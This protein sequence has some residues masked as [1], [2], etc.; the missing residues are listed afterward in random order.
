MEFI[1]KYIPREYLAL[2]IN[3]CR[4]RLEELPKSSIQTHVKEG[5]L[6]KRIA[7]GSHRYNL[8]SPEGRKYYK[9]WLER[10][11]H[12]RH[13]KILNS[14]WNYYFKDPPSSDCRPVKAERILTVGY[15]KQVVMDKAF[16]D[17]LKNDVNT[18]H[19]KYR[20]YYFNGTYYRSA[21][22][23]DI[24]VFYT[25]MGIPFKYEPELWLAGMAQPIYPDFVIYIKELDTCIIHEHI[26]IKNSVD[27][28]RDIK[29]KYNNYVDAG[30]LSGEDFIFTYD[31]ERIHFDIR[32][33]PVELNTAVYAIT[34]SSNP[35][36]NVAS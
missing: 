28:L 26:G 30:L 24:A 11:E 36:D 2:K 3:Y 25:E 31:T 13:I 32:C 8:D 1:N 14:I 33:L 15:G 21:A 6:I 4:Q 18:K 29:I 20:N 9:L 23:R 12:E 22:E 34:I 16:F 5:V 10:D 17:D 27:Y 7:V 19:P 35:V